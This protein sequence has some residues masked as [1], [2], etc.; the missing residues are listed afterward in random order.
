MTHYYHP[1]AP[2]GLPVSGTDGQA[3]QAARRTERSGVQLRDEHHDRG[4][5]VGRVV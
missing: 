3:D 2:F 4:S 5:E 1:T